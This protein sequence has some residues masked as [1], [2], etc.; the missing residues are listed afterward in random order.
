MTNIKKYMKIGIIQSMAFP[1]S[2]KDSNK[3]IDSYKTIIKDNYFDVIEIGQIKDAQVREK[4]KSMIE[5]SKLIV[6]YGGHSRLL[7]N[8]LNINDLNENGRIAAVNQLKEGIDEA[9]YMNAV[10]FSFL[11]GKYSEDRKKTSLQA[12]IKSTK[13]LC[14]Y[15]KERGDMQVL[16]EVFDYNID[17]KSLLGPVELVKRYADEVSQE[18]S[19]F[20]IM[21]DLSHL[22]QLGETPAEAILPIKKYIK[23]VHIGNT[24][25]K[26]SILEAYGD[27]HPRFGFPNSENGVN[28][29]IDF[30]NVLLEIEYLNTKQPPIVSFEVKPRPYED[31]ELVIAGGKRVLNEAWI[32]LNIQD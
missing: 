24:V 32:K 12:L 4:I 26:D 5:L 10:S 27:Q 7:S 1:D 16:L 2:I 31:D 19:N 30:L 13:E 23:H 18:C 20:G 14:A 22:P 3:L 29:L 9:Y 17:K 25:I 28:E 15:A 21:V 6:S 8:A 11:S